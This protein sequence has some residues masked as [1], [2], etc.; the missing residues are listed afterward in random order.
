MDMQYKAILANKTIYKE[1]PLPANATTV[2]VGTAPGVDVRLSKN[3]FF[4]QFE[5]LF[6]N[7]GS[8]WVVTCSPNVYISAGS[9]SKL[10]QKQLVHG[11]ELQVKYHSTDVEMVSMSIMVDFDE[12]DQDFFRAIDL[13]DH[14]KVMIGGANQCDIR[15]TDKEVANDLVALTAQGQGW[16]LEEVR[17]NY[18]VYVNGT[19]IQRKALLRNH[20]F[21]ALDK[22]KFFVRGSRLYTTE[23]PE[24]QVHGL[25]Q[26][27]EKPSSNS[28]AY[29]KF[30][31]TTRMKT[32]PNTEEITVL[33]PPEMPQKPQESLLATLLPSLA[34]LVLTVLMRGMMGS[35]SGGYVILSA[36]MMGIGIL[37]SIATFISNKKKYKKG[38]EERNQKFSTYIDQKRLSIEEARKQER[39]ELEEMY[40]SDMQD[41]KHI[42]EFSDKLFD[43]TTTDDDF[44]EVYLGKGKRT[45]LRQIKY[46]EQEKIE[47]E[48]DLTLVPEKIKEEYV[49]LDGAPITLALS[50]YDAVGA[51]GPYRQSFQLLKNM[52]LDLVSRQYYTDLHLYFLCAEEH[53]SDIRWARWLP[54]VENIIPGIRNIV[55]DVT[56]RNLVFEQLFA[57]LSIEKG[58][59]G[60][61]AP[62]QERRIIFVLDDMG[63][64]QHPISQYIRNCKEK[65]VTFVFFSSCPEYIPQNCGALI[66]MG[67]NDGE[68]ELIQ[69]DDSQN[70]Q[71]FVYDVLPD[72]LV[73]QAS[74]KLAP[75]YCDEVSLEGSLTKNYSFFQMMNIFGPEDLDLQKNW[76]SANIKKTMRAPLGI[77]A[78]KETVYLDLHEKAHGPHGLVAGTTGSGKSEILQSYILSMAIHYH[79]YEVGFLIIDF[80]GGGMANQ[81]RN[82]PHMLGAIT[83]IDGKEIDRSL[84]SI[85][86]ELQKRQRL[87][88]EYDVNKIDDYIEKFKQG[89]TKIALPHLI[90][91]VDEFAELKADQPEFMKELISAARIG[92]SLGVHLILA[93]Q[94]PSG[95]VDDQ[96]WS[97][98][99]F[100]LCLK[101]QDQ[102]DSN[103]VLK[104]PLAAEIREPGRAYLQVGNNEIFELFQSAYS[105]GLASDSGTE[106]V[107]EYCISEKNIWGQEKILFQKKA[108]K[109]NSGGGVSQLDAIV[110][111]IAKYCATHD[112]VKLP[113][114][115][116]PSLPEKVDYP[117]VANSMGSG[118]AIGIY[119]D[120]DNQIQNKCFLD[121]DDKNTIIIGSSQYGKTNLLQLMVRT[122]AAKYS[123][124]QA[125]IYLIDFGSRALKNFEKLNHVGGVVCVSDDEKLKNLFKLLLDELE[126]RREKIAATGLSSFS[127][128]CE[129]GN[130]DLPHL[131]LF[132]DN[133]VALAE[134]YLQDDD[135]MITVAREGTSVGISMIITATQ[136]SGISYRYLSNFA[137][138]VALYLNDSSE[139]SNLFDH[140]RTQ[141]SDVKG[142]CLVEI[143]KKIMECQTYLAFGGETEIER[144]HEIQTLVDQANRVY[145][146]N[147][148]RKIPCIPAILEQESL[149]SDFSAMPIQGSFKIPI[150]L[151]YT[152]VEP[153]YLDFGR[154]GVMGLC[155]KENMGHKNFVDNLIQ[156]LE[157]NRE[158]YPSKVFII[159]DV[160]RKFASLNSFNVVE[161]YTLDVQE[162]PK[163][164]ARCYSELETRYNALMDDDQTG[165]IQPLLVLIIQNN[166]AAK[167][168]ADDFTAMDQ[169]REIMDRFRALNVCVIFSNYP[170]T[171]V[172][173]D[174]PEPLRMI[175]DAQHLIYF[176]SLNN[177]KPFDVA[178]EYVRTYRKRL[179]TGDAYYINDAEVT[180][181]KLVRS[182][183]IV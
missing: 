76:E 118:L 23:A 73:E 92:R 104:S 40:Y 96:I 24:I 173:Y 133:F 147:H 75:V 31:R 69:S 116:L 167:I 28:L 83:N 33:D 180:K 50:K 154:L 130:T 47:V 21:F 135:T 125:S 120:P 59:N 15:I 53:V 56:S 177:L 123:P 32:K 10:P 124:E 35:T 175:K 97:N 62:V 54:H 63:I 77:N 22:Y 91:V 178:Y 145:G 99:R 139:Y 105:G 170:N 16:Q 44:A 176:D 82:L 3:L 14:T 157:E 143:D 153:F 174:A 109:K 132:V 115:C 19:R 70:V 98:S 13:K 64:N 85:K 38:L 9:S 160:S 106:T 155:G 6:T 84:K 79:P 51:V 42:M 140:V 150:G 37:T 93:T 114:I 2:S 141:P 122:I 71:K 138:R 27:L 55:C 30:N 172:S 18:G 8:D 88:A 67:E 26:R 131:Y 20:D 159:D 5:L 45:S 11:D 165:K 86:A 181:L 58:R 107:K 60:E 163:I 90:I 43:R 179:G 68:A 57:L 39:Q 48:D 110:E 4:E 152:E 161:Q 111:Y 94:K 17:S 119:D 182:N 72:A 103:E 128:Y 29:P 108:S 121:I 74:L 81:F 134:L 126:T 1:I 49:A 148:A 158:Q 127:A 41:A 25:A 46:K 36:C 87:F 89:Q 66:R 146:T 80:K 129:A 12:V 164:I 144:V 137:N 169:Y 61:E 101:V 168:I 7:E 149:Q 136:T 112:V 142:R 65:G 183:P 151:T 34:M 102:N 171:A 166:D 162:T 156:T 113:P 95:Q 100:K 78:K 117:L 52:T